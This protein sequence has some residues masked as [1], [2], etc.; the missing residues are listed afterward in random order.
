MAALRPFTRLPLPSS[1]PHLPSSHPPATSLPCLRD[2]RRYERHWARRKKIT[3]FKR[4]P[5]IAPRR[6]DFRVAQAAGG[7]FHLQAPWPPH[8]NKTCEPFPPAHRN[9]FTL[10]RKYPL[11]WRNVEYL[12]EP[13]QLPRPRTDGIW[14]GEIIRIVHPP[15][16]TK[17]E[18]VK[19][20]AM[21]TR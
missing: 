15:K 8:I 12:Y 20:R 21:K 13:R 14:G 5:N 1:C 11:R 19:E 10:N 6:E 17:E 16:K 4:M 9:R 3:P 7:Y 18:R 2:D